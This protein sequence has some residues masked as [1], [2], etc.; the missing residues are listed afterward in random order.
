M[1]LEYR[2]AV[3][4][5]TLQSISLEGNVPTYVHRLNETF[6]DALGLSADEFKSAF[7]NNQTCYS[8]MS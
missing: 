1:L 8:S 3:I 4:K 2:S 5:S 7:H 6:F